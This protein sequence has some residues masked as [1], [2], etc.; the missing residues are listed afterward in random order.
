LGNYS[1][2]PRYSSR[3]AF[4]GVLPDWQDV[5]GALDEIDYLYTQQKLC[6]GVT[7]YTTYGSK[8]LSHPS[9]V[10][11]WQKLQA[12]KALIFLHPG[13]LDV[14]PK[15]IFDGLPQPILDYPL[16][17][18][19]S[20]VDLVMSG[21]V[22]RYP[23]IDIIL[24]HAGGTIPFVGNRAI[25]ATV[26]PSIAAAVAVNAIEARAGFRHFYYDTA[27][28]ASGAQ[29]NGL[30]DFADPSRVIFG[31]DFPYA[32]PIAITSG[33]AEYA[34]FVATNSRGQQLS[35]SV[36]RTNTRTLLNKHSPGRVIT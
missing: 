34:A 33:L 30:L 6:L 23:D 32:P 15:F 7:V 2:E 21:T 12:Y 18:T 17:T 29:L 26:I 1:T 27:L 19:R 25:G 4:F 20:A 13:L 16:A 10:P 5:N 11:I 35:P 36:L 8:L 24:S 9:F 3:L 14:T 31:S 22:K 28:S